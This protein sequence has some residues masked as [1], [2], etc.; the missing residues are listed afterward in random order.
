MRNALRR[1]L[2]RASP[3]DRLWHVWLAAGVGVW[4]C[5]LP[6]RLRIR[7]LSVVLDGGRRPIGRTRLTS[8]QEMDRVVRAVR[9]VCRL[10]LFASRW[11]P[12]L[13]LR[14]A[15]ALHRV[16]RHMGCPARFHLGVHTRGGRFAAHGWVTVH[17]KPVVPFSGDDCVR[18]IYSHPA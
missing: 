5:T 6:V 10:R 11:F 13:C 12:R 2:R 17:G 14:E 9:H 7:S 8:A 18:T 15:L 16:L 1:V 4:L 3:I